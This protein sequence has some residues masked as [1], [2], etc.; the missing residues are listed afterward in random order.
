MANVHQFKEGS[1]FRIQV[2]GG[3]ADVEE[4]GKWAGTP[5]E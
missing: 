5:K 2:P 4:A 1:G 3:D